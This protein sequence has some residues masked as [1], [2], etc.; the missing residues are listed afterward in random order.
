MDLFDLLKQRWRLLVILSA[1]GATLGVF[2]SDYHLN[3]QVGTVYTVIVPV[4]DYEQFGFV[5]RV[6]RALE[7]N[8][9]KLESKESKF[10]ASLDNLTAVD[11]LNVKAKL[12]EALARDVCSEGYKLWFFND[13]IE[14]DKPLTRFEC[15]VPT[16][17]TEKFKREL[18]GKISEIWRATVGYARQIETEARGNV[19]VTDREDF[20]LDERVQEVRVIEQRGGLFRGLVSVGG[21]FLGFLLGIGIIIV[22]TFRDE[23]EPTGDESL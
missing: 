21:G 1:L 16:E 11:Q 12:V 9:D 5:K 18:S 20:S 4:P 8:I 10:I 2:A 19:T 13:E 14:F 6:S 23:A 22:L 17:S 15:G 3:A 7:L